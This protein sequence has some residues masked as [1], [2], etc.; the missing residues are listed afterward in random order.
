MSESKIKSALL[1][2]ILFAFKSYL[3]IS[4]N[5]VIPEII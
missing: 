2:T 3:L 4:A 1:V 5:L